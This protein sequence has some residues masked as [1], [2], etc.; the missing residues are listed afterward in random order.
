MA[1]SPTILTQT[2]Q[3]GFC[4]LTSFLSV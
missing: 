1:R 2:L 3:R 4:A